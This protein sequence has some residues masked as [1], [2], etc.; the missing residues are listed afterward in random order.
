LTQDLAGD[1]VLI[2]VCLHVLEYWESGLGKGA[3]EG[4]TFSLYVNLLSKGYVRPS[5]QTVIQ[6]D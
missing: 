3:F 1:D 2:Q 4:H 5:G 6:T